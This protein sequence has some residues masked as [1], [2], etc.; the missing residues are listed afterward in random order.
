MSADKGR[1]VYE[2]H[3][4]VDAK[5]LRDEGLTP[6]R[7]LYDQYLEQLAAVWP[8]VASIPT[9]EEAA[10]VDWPFIPPPEPQQEAS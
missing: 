1:E 5:A 3:T 6:K 9:P 10:P 8:P 4:V 7:P 2:Q